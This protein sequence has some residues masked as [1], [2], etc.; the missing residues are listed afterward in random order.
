MS[1]LANY[2]NDLFKSK[3]TPLLLKL[4]KK[5]L[6]SLCKN[7]VCGVTISLAL[8]KEVYDNHP[9]VKDPEGAVYELFEERGRLI[10]EH[11]GIKE[12]DAYEF[13]EKLAI[14]RKLLKKGAELDLKRTA[15]MVLIDW[16]KGN[17][18]FQIIL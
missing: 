15:K 10:Q 8:A 4:S 14:K 7:D 5:D 9:K 16:Q 6:N 3:T 18:S 1:L 17:I 2:T 13:L 11:Y 12:D